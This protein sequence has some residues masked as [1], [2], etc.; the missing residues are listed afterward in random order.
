VVAGYS[1]EALDL[2]TGILPNQGSSD[3]FV[4][5]Y[6]GGD[7]HCLW[8][9][10]FGGTGADVAQAVAVD[11]NNNIVL[12]G[13][14][15]FYGSG[16]NFGV[17][18][19]PTYGN[20]DVFVAKLD[21]NGNY[22]WA[23]SWGGAQTDL[24]QSMA[25]DSQGNV[26]VGGRFQGTANF[27]GGN[28]TSAGDYDVWFSKYSGVDGSPIWSGHFG[29]AQAQA[30]SGIAIGVN[31]EVI[32]SG[33]FSGNINTT[34]PSGSS[35]P[36]LTAETG[37]SLYI[38]QYDLNGA[39][40]WSKSYGGSITGPKVNGLETDSSGNVIVA[41]TMVTGWDFGDFSTGGF[42]LGQGGP[43]AFVAKFRPSDGKCLWA[44]RGAPFNDSGTALS[45]DR[46]GNIFLV[47]GCAP[48]EDFG[49]GTQTI[50]SAVSTPNSYLT[51]FGP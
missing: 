17:G 22:I 42:L 19:L 20:Q 4:A 7:G 30:L 44:K 24:A 6:A 45:V 34:G 12:V 46:S 41:G 43:D 8:A 37:G 36:T 23:K 35:G 38:I 21:S 13:Y 48:T 18:P 40:Q 2:G 49:C 16:I 50:T 51:R 29:D 33:E 27:G 11:R 5:K 32:I 9:K 25:L 31:N 47:G 1:T 14:H 28:V 39:Y 15:A 26:V 10:V 3:I